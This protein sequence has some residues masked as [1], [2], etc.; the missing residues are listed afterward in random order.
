MKILITII[1]ALIVG[2]GIGVYGLAPGSQ[3]AM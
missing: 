1:V 3:Q 2:A